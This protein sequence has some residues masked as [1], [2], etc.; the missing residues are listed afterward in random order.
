[1]TLTP[2][3]R[4]DLRAKAHHLHPVVTI[5]Q[6]GLTAAVLLEIDLALKAHELIK[7]RVFSDDRGVR[8]AMATSICDELACVPVQHLGKLLIVWRPRPEEA[9]EPPK[10]RAEASKGKPALRGARKP[11][12]R[13]EA[14]EA[15]AP[16]GAGDQ[17]RRGRSA[18][19][20]PPSGVPRAAATRRRRRS[21]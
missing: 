20:A 10:R 16:R 6:Q 12:E 14:S 5:G 2:S 21:P 7:V 18:Q 11:R 17:S 15:K 13:V 8:E 1:M 3:Q 19:A 4:R 9:P